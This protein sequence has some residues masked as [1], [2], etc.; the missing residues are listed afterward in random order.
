[1]LVP[2]NFL[3]LY[4]RLIELESNRASRNWQGSFKATILEM[5]YYRTRIQITIRLR[6]VV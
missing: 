2:F 1:M 5:L 4:Y 6:G 3:T